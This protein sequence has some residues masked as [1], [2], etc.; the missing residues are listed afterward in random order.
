[1]TRLLQ[2]CLVTTNATHKAFFVW[3]KTEFGLQFSK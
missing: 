1:M 3:Y 2:Q